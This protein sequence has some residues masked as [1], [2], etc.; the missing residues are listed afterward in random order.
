MFQV[1]H[2]MGPFFFV[3]AYM[4]I[5]V[6]HTAAYGTLSLLLYLYMVMFVPRTASYGCMSISKYVSMG[7]FVSNMASGLIRIR[8]VMYE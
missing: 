5:C 7:T 6:S 3:Y 4:I 1:Q 2:P 8:F